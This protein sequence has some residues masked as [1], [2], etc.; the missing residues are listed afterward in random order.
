MSDPLENVFKE[1][2][3]WITM[4]QETFAKR[5]GQLCDPNTLQIGSQVWHGRHCGGKLDNQ[6]LLIGTVVKIKTDAP[7]RIVIKWE[8]G[9][10]QRYGHKYVKTYFW[11]PWEVEVMSA[12]ER[13]KP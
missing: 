13:H 5:H 7:K 2:L 1:H 12:E 11:N 6:P 4:D 9:K 3:P 8:N 10:T